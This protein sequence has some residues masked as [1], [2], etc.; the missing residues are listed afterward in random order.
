MKH[1]K[2]VWHSGAITAL[3]N[4]AR[5]LGSL[6]RQRPGPSDAELMPGK[7]DTLLLPGPSR[8]AAPPHSKEKQGGT[9]EK[10]E[11]R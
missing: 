10:K 5:I 11:P 6:P 9:A 1:Q 3:S 7:A 4:W 2:Q 8:Q